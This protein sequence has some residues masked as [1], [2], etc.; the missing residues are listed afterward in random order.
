MA[1]SLPFVNFAVEPAD[2]MR[3]EC[4]T[5]LGDGHFRQVG[6]GFMVERIDAHAHVFGSF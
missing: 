2:A 4:H 1:R 3:V 6:P 5:L